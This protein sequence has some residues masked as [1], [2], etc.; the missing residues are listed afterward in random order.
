MK[1]RIANLIV[2]IF[3]LLMPVASLQAQ[4]DIPTGVEKQLAQDRK[5]R[6]SELHYR[7][8]FNI[9]E[10]KSRQVEAMVE[11]ELNLADRAPLVIDF[12]AP[13]G[14]I[15]FVRVNSRLC[16]DFV[17]Q[18]EHIVLPEN[19]L[20]SGRNQVDI[21]FT[22]GDKP[23]NRN[24]EYLYTLLVPDRARTL[25]PCFDQPDLKAEY[26]LT[27]EVPAQWEAVSNTV[28]KSKELNGNR[29]MI[30]FGPTE[31]LST[32]LF[33][34]VVG[35]FNKAT[36]QRDGR[37]ISAYYRES[38][39][40]KIAQIDTIFN[41]IFDALKWQED[42]TGIKYPFAKYD[43]IILPGFQF[44][45]ME[46]TGATLYNDVR[47]WLGETPTLQ[48]ELDRALLIAHET[49]H[50]WF[51]DL[52]TMAWFDD[53]WTKE[54]FANYYA[55]EIA[56]PMF[57][58]ANHALN[59]LRT[60]YLPALAEDR[61]AG[62]TPIQQELPNLEYA[63]LVYNNIIYDKAPVMMTK[64]VDIMG[65]DA[66]RDGI[67][68][69]LSKYAYS[70]ATWDDLVEILDS[71]T[72]ADLKQFCR[73][74]VKEKGMPEIGFELSDSA[75]VVRQTDALG[76][77]LVW[78]QK[79]AVR[80][81]ADD[82][83]AADVEVVLYGDSARI[84]LPF[85]PRYVMPNLDGRGY[86]YFSMSETNLDYLREN[87]IQQESPL[88]RQTM[89]MTIYENY[90]HGKLEAEDMAAS[91]LVGLRAETDPLVAAY[92]IDCLEY[93]IRS[94][95]NEIN[96]E[97]QHAVNMLS[98]TVPDKSVRLQLRRML[99]K[100]MT[101]PDIVEEIYREWSVGNSE[102]WNDNDYTDLSYEL[103][104]RMPD[105]SQEILAQQRLRISNQDKLREFDFVSRTC[106]ADAA[107]RDSLFA[108]LLTTE[109]RENEVFA[110]KALAYLNHFTRNEE[111]V[112]Y[113]RPA[114]DALETVRAE[115][116]IFFPGAW[117][118]SLLT[119]HRG[120]AACREVTRFLDDNP[121]YL[122]LLR[123]KILT[124]AYP[125]FQ[126]IK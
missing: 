92:L 71:H 45:G 100:V 1:N 108:E 32:Y 72:D 50:M 7:L 87:W 4:T 2:A 56:E 52:V 25:F 119:G 73:V 34:F 23:L 82:E 77:G 15:H 39:P 89:I 67:R 102:L 75:M 47:M 69:Y 121:D 93:V 24:D 54:V 42:Y 62:S 63:G 104:I 96:S 9:P 12:K 37:E 49:S 94:G 66:F 44:G 84:A 51:G 5:A 116:D 78:P 103:A 8:F 114:L 40:R 58:N 124:A 120:E 33:S 123:N 83:R 28:I 113:I 88:L 110:K 65:K 112:R 22:A 115:G 11:I 46:H 59:R 61:T 57:P 13:S 10:E 20:Q 99:A 30:H 118:K 79:F 80:V 27:L 14:N 97:I 16:Q 98:T 125:M 53:V 111:S 29:A 64:L 55:A 41:Q 60:F 91:L 101:E 74:W 17:V 3:L 90:L 48:E 6:I 95:N 105:K 107:Q 68:E 117:C 122:P 106:S 70:N 43:F 36:K 31:P 126:S 38:D 76:R 19:Y 21:V 35:K 81:V 26:E 86:A 18:N 85:K 109:G